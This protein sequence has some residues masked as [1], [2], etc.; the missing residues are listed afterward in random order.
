MRALPSYLRRIGLVLFAGLSVTLLLCILVDPLWYHQGNRL[1]G[2]NIGFNERVAKLNRLLPRTQDF[3]C[4]I[5]GSSRTTLLNGEYFQKSRC[6]NLAV[7]LGMVGEFVAFAEYLQKRGFR[8]TTV[9][10]G[11]DAFNFFTANVAA[12]IPDHVRRHADPPH[13]LRSYLTLDALQFSVR[14]LLGKSPTPRYYTADFSVAIEAGRRVYR[15][16]PADLLPS[17]KRRLPPARTFQREHVQHYRRLLDIYADSDLTF[18]VPPISLWRVHD[19]YQRGE[20]EGYLQ[21]IHAVAQLGRPLL[22]FSVPSALTV[23]PQR[24]YDGSHYDLSVNQDIARMLE[25]ESCRTCLRVDG[26]AQADYRR[27]FAFAFEQRRTQVLA[28]HQLATRARQ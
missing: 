4:V 19:F 1:T 16:N 26:M 28:E 14:G 13:W 11:V 18:Y 7:S 8:P 20:I 22:D 2:R 5:L 6:F 12:T 9:Y 27:A 24:T 25:G 15:P 17:A 21:G 23:D 10:V 3:D